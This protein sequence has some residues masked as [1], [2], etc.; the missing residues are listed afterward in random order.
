MCADTSSVVRA[1]RG[2]GGGGEMLH[3]ILTI[4][5]LLFS[6]P[7]KFAWSKLWVIALVLAVQKCWQYNTL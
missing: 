5:L 6:E 1:V 2:L 4:D 7:D 3:L